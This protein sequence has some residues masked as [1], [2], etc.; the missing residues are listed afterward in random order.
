MLIS[1]S[2]YVIT[3]TTNPRYA[4]PTLLLFCPLAGIVA[5][6]GVRTPWLVDFV[7]ATG[8]VTAI[9]LA[10]TAVG[11][12]AWAWHGLNAAQYGF[13]IET[14]AGNLF[15]ILL[16]GCAIIAAVVAVIC[17][18]QFK[19]SWTA[20][21]GLVVLFYTASLPFGLQRHLAHQR[22]GQV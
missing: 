5:T 3:G 14:Q 12:A 17:V 18:R 9:I 10:G 19:T 20:S 8:R 11:L 16:V 2:I 7:R 13:V 15:R 6:A 22:F 4:Y 1:W 21:W